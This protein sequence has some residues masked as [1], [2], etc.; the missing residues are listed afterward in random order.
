MHLIYISAHMRNT[1]LHFNILYL[2][3][4]GYCNINN[5]HNNNYKFTTTKKKPTPALR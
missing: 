3:Y 2:L 1:V 5:V 4:K